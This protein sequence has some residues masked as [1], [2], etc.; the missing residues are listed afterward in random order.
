[1]IKKIFK[2]SIK[3]YGTTVINLPMEPKFLHA[4]SAPDGKLSVWLEVPQG[5][6]SSGLCYFDVK[7]T[8]DT[9]PKFPHAS[10]FIKYPLVFHLFVSKRLLE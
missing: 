7:Y 1:M 4:G 6:H 8:G 2:Y 3:E 9:A 10:T 5:D